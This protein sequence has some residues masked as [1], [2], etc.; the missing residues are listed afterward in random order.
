MLTVGEVLRRSAEYLERHGIDT[1]RLDAD[2]L[3]GHALGM[4][5]MRLYLEHDRP[6]TQDELA[7]ARALVARRGRRE[8]V[9]YILGTR[10]FR[11]LQLHVT[12]DVLVPRPDTETL[13]EWAVEAAPQGGRRAGLGHRQRRGWPWRWRTSAP[14]CG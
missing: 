5:R 3:L 2:L 4:D 6:L 10:A 12:P 9:A 7:R 14:T 11:G 1:P 13:V 8:P